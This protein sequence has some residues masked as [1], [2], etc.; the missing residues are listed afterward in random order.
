MNMG[1]TRGHSY[2]LKKKYSVLGWRK[3]FFSQRI[4]TECNSLSLDIVNNATTN[5]L[6]TRIKPLFNGILRLNGHSTILR[7]LPSPLMTTSDR[8]YY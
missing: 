8:D 3:Y 2:K 7:P 4:V 6:K 1:N 5:E